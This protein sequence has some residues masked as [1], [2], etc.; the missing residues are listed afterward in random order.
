MLVGSDAEDPKS[1]TAYVLRTS[2]KKLTLDDVVVRAGSG[3]S[4]TNG[5]D[6]FAGGPGGSATSRYEPGKTSCDGSLVTAA[7]G[8]SPGSANDEG[9]AA[10]DCAA[11]KPAHPG[12]TGRAG[13]AGSDGARLPTVTAEGLL[14]WGAAGDGLPDAVAGHGGAGG[15]RYEGGSGGGGGCPGKPG[16]AGTVAGGSVCVLALGGDVTITRSLLHTGFAG[17]GGA[18]GAGGPGGAGGI[19]SAPSCDATCSI[20]TSDTYGCA[21]YGASGGAGGAGAHGGGAGGGWVLGVVTVKSAT[22]ALDSSTAVELGKP[23]VGGANGISRGPDG[24]KHASFHI[25]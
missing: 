15:C 14:Q 23:G 21:D 2:A 1:P 25:D 17:A 20:C 10:G 22:A 3:L 8:G 16:T 13:T 5:A 9:L 4:G 24:E 12:S 7:L 11:M 19:G 18:G 6:G